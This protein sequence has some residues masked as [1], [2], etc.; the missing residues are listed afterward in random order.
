M[1]LPSINLEE[2]N[3]V[4]PKE[5][6][7]EYP[8]NRREE[9]RLLFVD[10]RS[11]HIEHHKF[12]EISNLIPENSFLIL[13]STKVIAARINLF[14]PTGGKIELLLIEP[15]L[16]E[17][18]PQLALACKSPVYWEC[19]YGGRGV[20]VGTKLT[21]DILTAEIIEKEGN[22]VLVKFEWNNQ[23]NSFAKILELAGKIPL[24]PYIRR[25]IEDI[26]TLRYQT[27]YAKSD[28]SI[29]APTAGLHFTDE[30]F[31]ELR[32]KGIGIEELIL[33]VGPG[34]FLPI[35]ADEIE[36]HIMHKEAI[37]V[38][39]NSIQNILNAFSAGKRIIATGTTSVR[40][41]ES[42]YWWGVKLIINPD[43]MN[44]QE[45]IVLQFEPY[46]YSLQS[47]KIN[48]QESFS[49]ILE[50][51]SHNDSEMLTGKTQLF[52]VPGYDYKIVN[53]MITN[54]HLPKS[55][56]I[57]LVATFLGKDLWKESYQTALDNNYRFLSYG[58]A[59]LLLR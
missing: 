32:E 35:D 24:P 54:F 39:K 7:A 23:E 19:F 16:P 11:N 28:G 45:L 27:V 36:N 1:S 49:K 13:N 15:K 51:M 38:A 10:S 43:L 3:Y 44:S 33:H 53:G 57:L 29:A 31:K 12:S 52:I 30:I 22:K 59:S 20:N 14:K 56:L 42:M 50:W 41:L 18:D 17:K 40:T 6:V 58:D 9:S 47:Q 4:L 48:P 25:N 8:A 37:F 2:F 55:T 26:D 34:T 5:K 21:I 46:Q